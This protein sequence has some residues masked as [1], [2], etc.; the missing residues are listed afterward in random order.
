MICCEVRRDGLREVDVI[1]VGEASGRGDGGTE[2]KS[3]A[4]VACL[5][6]CSLVASLL[7]RSAVV[8]LVTLSQVADVLS[9]PLCHRTRSV[10]RS[11]RLH[12]KY[13]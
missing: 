5:L 12:N 10:T 9:I 2:F 7:R 1:V 6:V 8:L 3:G 4:M 13:V 11:I